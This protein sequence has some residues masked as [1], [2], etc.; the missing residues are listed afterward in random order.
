M[1]NNRILLFV[2]LFGVPFFLIYFLSLGKPVYKDVVWDRYFKDHNM[3]NP[4]MNNTPFIDADSNNLRSKLEGKIVIVNNLIPS[5]PTI[6]PVIQLQMEKLIYEEIFYK[7]TFSDVVFVSNLI[8]TLGKPID[9]KSFVKEQKVD[10][11]RWFFVSEADSIYNI[12]LAEGKNLIKDNPD[13]AVGG[14]TYYKLLLLFDAKKKLRGIYQGDQTD[15]IDRLLK[16]LRLII[17]EHNKL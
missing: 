5:C 4:Y 12:D 2:V 16:E 6:C 9:L 14:K 15:D 3:E 13:K 17:K 1:N 11:T 8:D 10:N 7:P